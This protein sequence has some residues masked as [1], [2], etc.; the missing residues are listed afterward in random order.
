MC[1]GGAWT[2]MSSIDDTVLVNKHPKAL[3]IS[4]DRLREAH[5]KARKHY[6]TMPPLL[7][8]V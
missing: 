3:C 5:P 6:P 8:I 2:A 7:S 4:Y 1:L